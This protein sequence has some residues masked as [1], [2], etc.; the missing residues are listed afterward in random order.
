MQQVQLVVVSVSSGA[1]ANN[2]PLVWHKSSESIWFSGMWSTASFRNN[3]FYKLQILSQI[4]NSQHEISKANLSE[5]ALSLQTFIYT[6]LCCKK[7]TISAVIVNF[8][9]IILATAK[10]KK[11]I[12]ILWLFKLRAYCWMWFNRLLISQLCYL[13]PWHNFLH[14]MRPNSPNPKTCSCL[15]KATKNNQFFEIVIW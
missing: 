9:L 1:R 2:Q 3:S 5:I 15:G 6:G 7:W 4:R 14:D 13:R 10:Q 12:R 8:L 11:I